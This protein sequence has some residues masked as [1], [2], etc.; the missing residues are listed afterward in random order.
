MSVLAP[1]KGNYSKKWE[2]D[3]YYH[4]LSP[5]CNEIISHLFAFA[6][7]VSPGVSSKIYMGKNDEMW[8]LYGETDW[9]IIQMQSAT[10]LWQ[11]YNLGVILSKNTKST[12]SGCMYLLWYCKQ[13][14][15]KGNEWMSFLIF[16]KASN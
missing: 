3:M 9:H 13:L 2:I 1:S 10:S 7:V 8:F 16:W 6:G 15:I 14:K 5:R 11:T 4:T 12:R